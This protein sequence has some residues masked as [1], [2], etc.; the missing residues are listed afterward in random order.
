M[1]VGPRGQSTLRCS[2]L[3]LQR[4]VEGFGSNLV[5]NANVLKGKKTKQTNKIQQWDIYP[6]A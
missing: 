3:L 4:G 6:N 1:R 2:G 5:N